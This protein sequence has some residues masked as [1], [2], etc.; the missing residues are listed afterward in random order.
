MEE[1][2]VS[3]AVPLVSGF[4]SVCGY[5]IL[6]GLCAKFGLSP[7]V[8]PPFNDSRKHR[9]LIKG[10][11][12]PS[13]TD[14]WAPGPREARCVPLASVSNKFSWVWL[15]SDTDLCPMIP[16]EIFFSFVKEK[17]LW[18]RCFVNSKTQKN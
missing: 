11:R 7:F 2:G 15:L 17:E 6:G 8:L 13:R 14:F 10:Q 18:S 3:F 1:E 9:F 16:L 12:S 5:I 4:S